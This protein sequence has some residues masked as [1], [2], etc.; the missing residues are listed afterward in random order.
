MWLENQWRLRLS[1]TK[2]AEFQAV[3]L[4]GLHTDLVADELTR[5]EF[6]HWNSSMK[7]FRDIWWG[8]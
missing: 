6:H 3:H 7:G 1:E 4:K 5:S 2:A 8:D